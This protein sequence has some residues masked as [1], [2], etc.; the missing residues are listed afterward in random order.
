M[1]MANIETFTVT[2]FYNDRVSSRFQTRFY[3]LGPIKMQYMA[4]SSKSFV[5]FC[6]LTPKSTMVQTYWEAAIISSV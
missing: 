2:F 1:Y 6:G 5:L 3:T 4:I